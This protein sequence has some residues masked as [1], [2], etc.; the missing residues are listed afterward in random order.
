MGGNIYGKLFRVS[1]FG[2]SHGP[3]LGVVVDGVPANLE[4][5]AADIQFEL[6]RRR[7]GQS[8][9]TTARN[10]SDSVE[11]LSGVFEGKT[12]GTALA[13]LIRN[14]DQHSGDYGNIAEI[15]RPGH[16][17]Y[18]YFKKY[19]IRDYRGGGR[20]SGRETI[21]RVAAGAIAKKLLKQHNIE[22]KAYTKQLL[23]VKAKTFDLSIIEDNPMRCPDAVAAAEMY[24]LV[25]KLQQEHDS[26]GG[27]VECVI[28]NLPP[29][30][31]EPVF[32]KLDAELGKA[33]LSLGGVKGIEFGDGFE[34]ANRRGSENNDQMDGNGF[35]SNHA[36]GILGGISNGNTVIFRLA[37]KGTPSIAQEQRCSNLR[38]ESTSCVIKGRHDPVLMPRLAVVVEAMAALVCVD[39]W[40]RNNIE[41]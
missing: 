25:Q 22:I 41:I 30:L 7:P 38:N 33:M 6:S 34:V 32:D 40:M 1:T 10:E 13:M 23:H 27:I 19:G 12:T 17:D 8:K 29:G 37:V 28:S 18:T 21:G 15:F 39:M 4:L 16:A 5:S 3:A 2:E 11:I 26:G 31:G 36:G 20:S 35:L 14:Q 24:D 9:V